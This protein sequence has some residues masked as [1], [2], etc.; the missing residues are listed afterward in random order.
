MELKANRM[1][2]RHNVRCARNC[3]HGPVEIVEEFS[4]KR[5][6]TFQTWL[7]TVA[8]NRSLKGVA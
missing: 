1:R 5:T 8:R 6:P 7:C 3:T 2:Q 4:L